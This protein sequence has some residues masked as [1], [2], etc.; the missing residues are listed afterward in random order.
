M[1]VIKTF[2]ELVIGGAILAALFFFDANPVIWAICVMLFCIFEGKINGMFDNDIIDRN[3]KKT[4][5]YDELKNWLNKNRKTKIT[6][7]KNE[8]EQI[9]KIQSAKTGEPITLTGYGII[10]PD[11]KDTGK[12]FI[13]KEDAEEYARRQH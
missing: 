3:I 9:K 1:K 10:D 2:F 8:E 12:R 4:F 11:G 6:D 5:D 7:K 13:R